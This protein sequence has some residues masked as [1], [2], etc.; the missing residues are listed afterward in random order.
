VVLHLCAVRY[1]KNSRGQMGLYRSTKFETDIAISRWNDEE[2]GKKKTDKKR[3]GS[4]ASITEWVEMGPKCNL[5]RWG[6][7]TAKTRHINCPS[8]I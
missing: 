8:Q 4:H 2:R 6:T 7:E 3:D 1:G 5:V